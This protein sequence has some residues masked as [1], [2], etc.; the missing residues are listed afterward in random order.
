MKLFQR[1]KIPSISRMP[2][3]ADI[4]GLSLRQLQEAVVQP[5]R[6]IERCLSG[7]VPYKHS[8]TVSL[9][10]LSAL[11]QYYPFSPFG[12]KNVKL[13]PGGRFMFVSNFRVAY[14]MDLQNRDR[15]IWSRV[16]DYISR[17]RRAQGRFWISHIAYDC[18]EDGAMT[19]A[20]VAKNVVSQ[21]Q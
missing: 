4:Q 17:D 15:V 3:H 2:A 13:F 16:A 11:E 19:L 6:F 14:I 12:T 8:R 9:A 10:D 21:G 7:I 20:V 18:S 5:A 1:A